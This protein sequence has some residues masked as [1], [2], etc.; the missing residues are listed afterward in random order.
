[1]KQRCYNEND[2]NYP[3]YGGRGIQVCQK[4][5]VSSKAF[6]EWALSNGYTDEL[7]LDRKDNN[8]NYTPDNCRW[9]TRT[10]Q[11][12]NR[13][14]G[15]NVRLITIGDITDTFSGW[16]KRTG[17]PLFTLKSRYNRDGKRGN[18]LIKE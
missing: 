3:N 15:K 14:L 6:I 9:A 4:W 2:I 8:G 5:I 18:D 12:N 13:R 1:M 17:I 16:S 10:E 11:Q 7:T